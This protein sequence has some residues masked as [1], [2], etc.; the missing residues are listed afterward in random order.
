MALPEPIPSSAA[1]VTGASSGIG[2][3]VARQLAG[4]GHN[5]I[6]VAR[7][8]ER[9]RELTGELADE[10]GVRVEPL[11]VDLAMQEARDELAAA[12]EAL[13]L[14]VEVLV[15]NAG[16]G[17]SGNVHRAEPERLRAMVRLNCEAVVDLQARY[18]AAMVERERGAIINIA[19][20]ASFQPIPGTATYAATKAF[21]LSLSEATHAELGGKGIT[22]T[23]VCPGP[24]KTEFAEVAG[25]GDANEKLPGFIWTDVEQVAREAVEGAEKDRRV[26]VPGLVNRAGAL[27]GQHTPRALVLPL[28][29]RAWRQAL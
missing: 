16:F 24:V 3:E 27:A 11:A 19:S 26:V 4:R 6:I 5:L 23:A 25:L 29:K 21:V 8:I 7:R 9:L 14:D 1:L 20:T 10:H 17:G 15:N 13:G 2:E 22:V 12:V 28:A 18:S